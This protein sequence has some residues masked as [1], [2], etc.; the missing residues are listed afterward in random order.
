[1]L[2][3]QINTLIL[4]SVNNSKEVL[5]LIYQSGGQCTLKWFLGGVL[6]ASKIIYRRSDLEE[7]DGKLIYTS[8]TGEIV[9]SLYY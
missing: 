3:E 9:V 8:R 5:N 4:V 2:H 7:N 6:Q 1:M